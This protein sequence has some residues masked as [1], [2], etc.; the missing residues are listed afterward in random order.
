MTR[1]QLGKFASLNDPGIGFGRDAAGIRMSHPCYTEYGISSF[2]QLGRPTAPNHN[3]KHQNAFA[4]D[5]QVFNRPKGMLS[6][7]KDSE[8][9]AITRKFFAF[10]ISGK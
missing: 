10:G 5:P 7:H 4:N 8:R 9:T 1:T 3:P 2:E 6:S